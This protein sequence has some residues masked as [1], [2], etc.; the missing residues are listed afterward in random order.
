MKRFVSTNR[1]QRFSLPNVFR[2]GFRRQTF[3]KYS[4]RIDLSISYWHSSNY[5]LPTA[6]YSATSMHALCYVILHIYYIQ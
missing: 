3:L 1:H 6:N 4:F 2:I 5:I